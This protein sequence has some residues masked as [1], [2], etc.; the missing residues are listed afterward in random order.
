MLI[1]TKIKKKFEI[2]GKWCAKCCNAFCLD[3]CNKST[4]LFWCK[5]YYNYY[6]IDNLVAF[7]LDSVFFFYQNLA[8]QNSTKTFSYCGWRTYI[9][10]RIFRFQCLIR[11]HMFERYSTMIHNF[12]WLYLQTIFLLNINFVNYRT[13]I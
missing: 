8:K 13:Q 7:R 10:C 11:V 9:N 5:I 1:L 4:P 6:K 2:Q 12:P 3:I